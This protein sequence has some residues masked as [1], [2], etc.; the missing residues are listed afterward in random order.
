MQLKTILNR[1]H[2]HQ[3]F[4]YADVKLKDEEP[5]MVLEVFVR[6]RHKYS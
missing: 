3:S 2:K 4:V 1:V 6:I 5:Q